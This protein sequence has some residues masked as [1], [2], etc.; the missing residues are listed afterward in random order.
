MLLETGHDLL[1]APQITLGCC[2]QAAALLLT[3]C[4]YYFDFR[5][6]LKRVCAH[7]LPDG[8][9]K[10]SSIWS[11]SS[12]GSRNA[13]FFSRKFLSWF[14]F[15]LESKYVFLFPA[16]TQFHLFLCVCMSVRMGERVYLYARECGCFIVLSNLKIILLRHRHYIA[17]IKVA[18]L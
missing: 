11:S 13:I 1:S 9:R 8:R 5:L 10:T 18:L 6:R 17:T 14:L 4:V 2:V 12:T 15:P 3:F 16:S 7:S